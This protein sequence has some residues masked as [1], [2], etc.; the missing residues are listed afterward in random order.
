MAQPAPRIMRAPLKKRSDVESTERG[1]AM[2]VRS[3]AAI[4]V[5]NKHGKYK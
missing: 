4:R 2:G 5:E 1:V 3:G